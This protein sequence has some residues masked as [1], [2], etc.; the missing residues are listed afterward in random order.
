[1]MQLHEVV[2]APGSPLFS[3]GHILQE[4]AHLWSHPIKGTAGGNLCQLPG[5]DLR[6]AHVSNLGRAVSR[7][8]DVG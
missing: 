8:Q 6:E 3:H 2:F 4:D 1:M 7:E 5:H